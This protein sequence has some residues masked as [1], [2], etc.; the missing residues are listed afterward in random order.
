MAVKNYNNILGIVSLVLAGLILASVLFG[1][2]FRKGRGIERFT[3]EK[4]DKK[5]KKEKKEEEEVKL[6]PKEKKILDDITNGKMTAESMAE[7]IKSGVF[8]KNNLENMIGYVRKE[9]F[10]NRKNDD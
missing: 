3:T 6:S 9:Q 2:H 8:T 7:Q 4:A 1:C 5:E 10:S